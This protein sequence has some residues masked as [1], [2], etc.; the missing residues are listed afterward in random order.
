MRMQRI[1][2]R[3]T[4]FL[5]SRAFNL[6]FYYSTQVLLSS[7]QQSRYSYQPQQALPFYC[8]QNPNCKAIFLDKIQFEQALRI[9]TLENFMG[10]HH[11]IRYSAV[12]AS[13]Y[14]QHHQHQLFLSF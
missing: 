10:W 11:Q 9:L 1:M 3:L 12:L 14:V 2:M 5:M 7:S 6:S 4:C 8:S 13:S